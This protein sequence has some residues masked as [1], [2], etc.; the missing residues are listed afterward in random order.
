MK[1]FDISG[2]LPVGTWS[3]EASAGTGKTYTIAALVTRFIAEGRVTPTHLA[4][5]TFSRAAAGE[6]GGRIRGQLRSSAESLRSHLAGEQLDL[7]DIDA[8]LCTGERPEV[9]Q[10]LIRLD[11]AIAGFDAAQVATIHEFCEAM[12]AELGILA[13]ADPQA[14][15]VDDLSILRTQVVRDEYL[16]QF[17]ELGN[18]PFSLKLADEIAE[19]ATEVLDA[20][21][22]PDASDPR[23]SFA[24]SVRSTM[25]ERKRQLGL[26]SYNDQLLRLRDSVVGEGAEAA[27]QRLRDRFQVILVDEFQDTDPT[28]W[29]IFRSCFHRHSTL[30]LIGDPKQAI[31]TFRGADIQ[32]YQDATRLADAQYS[33]DVNHRSDQ[34][35]V[36]AL[37]TV[38]H[39][40]L[41]SPGVAVPEVRAAQDSPRIRGVGEFLRLRFV[42]PEKVHSAV[43]ARKLIQDDLVSQVATLLAD[44][45]LLDTGSWRRLRG[46]DIAVL[47]RTNEFGR[48]VAT[49]LSQAQIP[50]AFSGADS[51]FKSRAAKH[52]C[53]LLTALEQPQRPNLRRAMFTDF[54][55]ATL[56]QLAAADDDR[57][58]AWSNLLAEWGQVL[59]DNGVA[60][61]FGAIGSSTDFV[62]RI[63]SRQLGERDLTDYRHVATLLHA[64][65]A[66][67]TRGPALAKWLADAIAM[68]R[69]GDEA[70]RKLDT[71]QDAVQV[72]T[73]HRA[74]GLQFPV[75]LLPQLADRYVPK[76]KGRPF[77]THDD[78]GGRI[79]DVGRL[80]APGR[81]SRFARYGEEQACDDLRQFYV[82]LTRAQSA[83]ICWWAK[84]KGTTPDSP[85]QRMLFR[86]RDELS[87]PRTRYP[88]DLPPGD[89]DPSGL[90]WLKS[91]GISA[92]VVE[93]K[94]A[95]QPTRPATQ[96]VVLRVAEFT[97]QIDQRWQ[98]T[99]YSGLTS[100]VHESPDLPDY[101]LE[102]PPA[103]A[104]RTET[105]PQ[106][107]PTPSP[108][109]DLPAGAAFGLVVHEVF[110][111]L[112][113]YTAD[114][115]ELLSRLEQ[116]CTQAMQH[117]PLRGF[118]ATGLARALLPALR[119]DL[120]EL[121]SGLPLS[122]IPPADRLS[123]LDFELPLGNAHTGTTL[124]DVA[125]LLREWLPAGDPLAEYPDRLAHPQLRGQVLRGFLTGSIDSVLRI[126]DRHL[127]VDYKTN[128][129]GGE[130]LL[131][132]QRYTPKAMATEMMAAHYPLQALLYCVALHRFL[133][134]RLIGYD[135]EKHLGGVGYL[136]VRGL[137][138]SR[139]LLLDGQP[140]G[141]FSWY[142]PTG[143]I[144]AVSQLLEDRRADE[145]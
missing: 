78:A 34:S 88:V 144:V 28:Q 49:K 95:P 85:L 25:A 127:V 54:I 24:L 41:L 104:P 36:S 43:E 114:D 20:A 6:L 107:C 86:R 55:G 132:L 17:A 14:I 84:A 82:A 137:A 116:A 26:Y 58:A 90:E 125:D 59:A 129:F 1:P 40:A 99:S 115:D 15:L 106:A 12:F 29:E 65:Y 13:T 5:V 61:L 2:P 118:S 48:A 42:D 122:A 51:V 47:V 130:G 64:Q 145:S 46:S 45:E 131:T 11:D 76:D 83:L 23:V 16:R 19:V 113:W 102:E 56:P 143:M 91:P 50:V 31:Y 44:G 69:S 62:S 74:K 80:G 79:T 110:E 109:A 53:T 139:Q 73:I 126:G 96:A 92:E 141:V 134:F 136:F 60:A 117:S 121:T 22:L 52:W 112:D 89:A 120:G 21:L 128:W 9:E 94:E 38:F 70:T 81:A 33:L 101:L 142:P 8:V 98:R 75:V 63:A 108:M 97:R 39:N 105:E 68:A 77:T 103:E 4:V 135:P 93:S 35:L 30:V 111:Y 87:L 27:R 66:A 138:G 3:L 37:N 100:A 119:T 72:M 18:P 124:A 67:G 32:T 140:S 57:I 7:A 123:E 133:S 10:R 71:D